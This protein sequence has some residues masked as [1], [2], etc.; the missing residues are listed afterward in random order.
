ML[1]LLDFLVIPVLGVRLPVRHH[2]VEIL[3]HEDAQFGF[4]F[5]DRPRLVN[6]HCR[7]RFDLASMTDADASHELTFTLSSEGDDEGA[8][9]L[10]GGAATHLPVRD[11]ARGVIH[12]AHGGAD[13]ILVVEQVGHQPVRIVDVD[14]LPARREICEPQVRLI[15]QGSVEEHACITQGGLAV[16]VFHRRDDPDGQQ[17]DIGDWSDFS[18]KIQ[19]QLIFLSCVGTNTIITLTHYL[20]TV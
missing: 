19:F 7:H 8:S 4:H 11:H 17:D 1:S 5:A 12:V 18:E 6:R 16:V 13:A 9:H 14:Y 20:N 15:R 3:P 2:L 10:H